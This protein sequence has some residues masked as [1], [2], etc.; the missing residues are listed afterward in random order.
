MVSSAS[1]ERFVEYPQSKD[2]QQ[3][4]SRVKSIP[5]KAE[6]VFNDQ[7]LQNLFEYHVIKAQPVTYREVFDVI[8]AIESEHELVQKIPKSP[9]KGLF[10]VKEIKER[11]NERLVELRKK[12]TRI[13]LAIKNADWKNK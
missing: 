11:I 10:S 9:L 3:F 13:H 2:V 8:D 1:M 12:N 7:G 6:K 5:L 4:G